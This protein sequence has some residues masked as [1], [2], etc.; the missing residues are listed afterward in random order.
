MQ[1]VSAIPA[2]PV[3]EMSRS[4]SF[5]CDTLGFSLIHHDG[6]FAIVRRDAVEVHLWEASDTSWETRAPAP[7]VVSG[8]E[9]FL[10]GTASCR[11]AVVGVDALYRAL[12]PHGMVHPNALLGDKPWGTREFGVLDPDGNLITLYERS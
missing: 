6:G 5:Y 12:E 3:R 11:I 7:R 8:A 1:F 9:S 2:L 4:I 10:A